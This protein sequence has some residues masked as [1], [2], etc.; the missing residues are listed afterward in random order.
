MKNSLAILMLTIGVV[1]AVAGLI[2][3]PL[4]QDQI[5]VD[6][7]LPIAHQKA[8]HYFRVVP[9]HQPFPDYLSYLFILLGFAT[10]IAGLA[11]RRKIR[12]TAA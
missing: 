6:L 5:P 8:H 11:M 4:V 3:T 12:T 2:G 1:I 7:I 10:S 9:A